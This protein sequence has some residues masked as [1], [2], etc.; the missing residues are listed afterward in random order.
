[1]YTSKIAQQR[2]SKGREYK[3]K[4]LRQLNAGRVMTS[5]SKVVNFKLQGHTGKVTTVAGLGEY[6]ASGGED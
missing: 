4:C 2:S 5:K 3:I 1:M 6:L